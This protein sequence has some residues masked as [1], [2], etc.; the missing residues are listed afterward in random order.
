MKNLRNLYSGFGT[1]AKLL[2][3]DFDCWTLAAGIRFFAGI[4]WLFY[5]GFFEVY[6]QQNVVPTYI[7][8]LCV[9]DSE[10]GFML[11]LP[12]ETGLRMHF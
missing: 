8:N 2:T 12:F 7:K 11:C 1:S 4:E 6:A 5:D 3:K 10:P 9:S